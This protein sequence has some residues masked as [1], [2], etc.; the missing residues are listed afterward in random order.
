FGVKHRNIIPQQDP[1]RDDAAAWG[2]VTIHPD[3]DFSFRELDTG[4]EMKPSVG[5]QAAVLAN[6][7]VAKETRS[8]ERWLNYYSP[9]PFQTIPYVAILSNSLP[10]R[11]SFSNKIFFVGETHVAGYVGEEK[12]EFRYP[13]T[14]WTKE[15]FHGVEIH[16]LTFSNLERQDWLRRLPPLVEAL[17]IVIAG[18][19][20]GYG[21]S[22]LRPIWGTVTAIAISL[23]V[24]AAAYALFAGLNIWF[25]WLI[26]V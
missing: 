14:W 16:A 23:T 6:P 26:I 7:E 13:W 5:W 15:F 18:A 12:E 24:T 1:L 10:E 22:R 21:L 19:A 2:L 17:I 9:R 25:P 8:E 4:I 11:T 20:L 3:P